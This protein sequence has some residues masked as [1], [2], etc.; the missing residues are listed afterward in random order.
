MINSKKMTDTDFPCPVCGGKQ[1]DALYPEYKGRCITSQLFFCE[2]IELDNR[3]CNTCGFIFNAKGIRGKEEDLYN[4]DVWKPKP[5]VLSFSGSV[6]STH[7]RAL[8]TFQ[9]LATIPEQGELLDFGAGTG[10]FLRC[11]ANTYPRWRLSAIEPGDGFTQLGSN[12][13]LSEAFSDP[14]YKTDISKQFDMIVVMSVLEHISDPVGAI[15]WMH[16]RIKPGG[17]LLMQHPNFAFLPGDLFCADH[18][19]KLTVPHTRHICENL[20]FELVA[21][22]A[23]MISFYFALRKGE[24]TNFSPPDGYAENIAMARAS[25]HIAVSTVSS[26]GEAVKSAEIS[27]KK[28]A[29]FGTS[30]IGSMAHLMLGCRERIACF[31]DE[32]KNVWGRLVDGIPVVGPDKMREM[33]VSDLALAISPLYWDK[34]EAKM[35]NYGVRVHRPQV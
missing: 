33:E 24:A 31:V 28:A 4:P 7:Q 8:E 19:N 26:V 18:I 2:D 15:R 9:S 25:E 14:Y 23:E 32:N 27:N 5:Q 10:A 11:F 35:G 13:E 20:G 34:V 1:Y 30:P 6:K 17:L 12:I 3:C 16:D 22:N 29:V 21:E